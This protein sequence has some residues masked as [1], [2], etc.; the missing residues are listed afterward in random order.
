[1]EKLL[2]V[3]QL[4]DILGLK[5]ITIYEWVRSNK[6]PFVKLGKRVLFQ[7]SDVEEFIKKNRV[8]RQSAV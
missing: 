2:N 1:M 5:K 3:N 7:P 4:A 8:E 6:I